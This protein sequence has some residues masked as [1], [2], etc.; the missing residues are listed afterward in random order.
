MVRGSPFRNELLPDENYRYIWERVDRKMNNVEAC[1][2]MVGVLYLAATQN[3]QNELAAVVI[4]LI[5]SNRKLK[6]NE[7][8]DRFTKNKLEIPVYNVSQHTLNSYNSFIPN[9]QESQNGK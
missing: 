6:L 9:Y 4:A 7:L 5:K 2:F 1:K 3:C 8:Q